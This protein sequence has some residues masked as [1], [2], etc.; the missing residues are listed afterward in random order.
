M[1]DVDPALV[2]LHR[3]IDRGF[4][5]WNAECFGGRLTPVVFAFFPQPSNGGDARL[6]HYLCGS[7]TVGK[8]SAAEIVF[9]ADLC[10]KAG[11]EQVFQTLVHEMVHHWQELE[12]KPGKK[13]HNKE[14]HAKA[15]AAGLQTEGPKG[16]TSPGEGF[17]RALSRFA[18]R[19]D[20]I[21]FRSPRGHG[22]KAKGKMRR[23]SCPLECNGSIRSG[24][25]NVFLT[26]GICEEPLEPDDQ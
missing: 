18:P 3:E 24:K 23:W 5:F 22:P 20:E 17:R 13:V 4:R 16:F 6:G 15:T 21:P 26:C 9:Y 1:T 10:L 8:E 12:G 2:G 7:W 25:A 19:T 14:W 11:P